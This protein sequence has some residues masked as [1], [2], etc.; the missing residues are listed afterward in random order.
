MTN[1]ICLLIEDMDVW[2]NEEYRGKP[3]EDLV[4]I[5]LNNQEPDKVTYIGASLEE[6]LKGEITSFLQ[7]NSDVFVW[8][9]ADMPGIDPQ[10][11][12]HKL[13]VDPTK[14]KI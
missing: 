8:T 2:E 13:N 3:A 11:I 12:T 5:P 6:P 4:P 9:A 10:L 7:E 14:K 1:Y